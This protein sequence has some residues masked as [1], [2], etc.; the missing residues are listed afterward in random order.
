M[1]GANLVEYKPT[2][3]EL[4]LA[5]IG[6]RI[7]I[8]LKNNSSLQITQ[9]IKKHQIKKEFLEFNS[10]TFTHSDVMGSGRFFYVENID[11]IKVELIK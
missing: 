8:L 4:I 3:E 6:K 7:K 11:T 1:L 9:I 2:P 5:E 10:Y